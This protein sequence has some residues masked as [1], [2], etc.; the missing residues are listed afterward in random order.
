MAWTLPIFLPRKRTTSSAHNTDALI[1]YPPLA[2]CPSIRSGAIALTLRSTRLQFLYEGS[3]RGIPQVMR[4]KLKPKTMLIACLCIIVLALIVWW[5]AIVAL[6]WHA[7]H[8]SIQQVGDYNIRVP[9]DFISQ[10]TPGGIRLLRAKL[11]VS[12]RVY[13][14]ES[15][16]VKQDP[17]VFEV[18]KWEV[19]TLKKLSDGGDTTFKSFNAVIGASP[20]VCITREQDDPAVRM[21]ALCKSVSNLTLE[22]FG[23]DRKGAVLREVIGRVYRRPT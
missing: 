20:S 18:R 3:N 19:L 14:F 8:S 7:G 15:V 16:E 22:Y 2:R 9:N 6:G 10:Q 1:S 21:V 17:G 12:S 13:E 11:V 4:G 23:N 5:P